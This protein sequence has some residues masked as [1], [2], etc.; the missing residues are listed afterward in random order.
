MEEPSNTY[1]VSGTVL[2]MISGNNWSSQNSVGYIILLFTY[3]KIYFGEG[4][5][6]LY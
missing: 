5:I 6:Q 1:D 4:G 2:G 3:S